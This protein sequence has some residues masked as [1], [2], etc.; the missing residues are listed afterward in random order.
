MKHFALT[1][2]LAGIVAGPALAQD[3]ANRVADAFLAEGYDFVEIQQ[4]LSQIKVEATRDGRTLEVVYDRATGQVL[5]R[6]LELAD[7]EDAART[8][9]EIRVRNRD[10][11][12]DSDD[13]DRGG[14]D[15]DDDD[16]SDDDRGGRDD[17]DDDRADDRGGRDDDDDDDDSDDDRGGRSDDDD[18]RSGSGGLRDRD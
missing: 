2:G 10:F 6:E 16:D 15:D 9:V 3:M 14:R 7:A 17:D 8:G 11:T 12:D 1:L 18:G 5:E 4:G 13:D